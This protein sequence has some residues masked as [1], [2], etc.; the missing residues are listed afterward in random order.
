MYLVRLSPDNHNPNPLNENWAYMYCYKW[1]RMTVWELSIAYLQNLITLIILLKNKTITNWKQIHQVNADLKL[2]TQNDNLFDYKA[3][4]HANQYAMSMQ[5]VRNIR[6][7]I[8]NVTRIVH[9]EMWIK[10]LIHCNHHVVFLNTRG[11]LFLYE[12][13]MTLQPFLSIIII[14]HVLT[15]YPNAC[16]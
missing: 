3:N 13:S 5:G 1:S 10:Q 6:K 7:R 12:K 14:M 15:G 9:P 11:S 16:S 2:N 4:L 8:I